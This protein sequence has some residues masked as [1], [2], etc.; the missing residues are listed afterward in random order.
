MAKK[1]SK[2]KKS[3]TKK[4]AKKTAK[5][6]APFDPFVPGHRVFKSGG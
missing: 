3:A 1:A 5:K 4:A 6:I 2:S